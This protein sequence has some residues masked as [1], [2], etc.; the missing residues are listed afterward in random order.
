M[1]ESE[2]MQQYPF[3]LRAKFLPYLINEGLDEKPV[4]KGE[5]YDSKFLGQSMHTYL[6]HQSLDG[7]RQMQCNALTMHKWRVG[8]EP[9]SGSSRRRQCSACQG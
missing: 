7:D 1:L 2:K 6:C 3:T 5:L 4:T 8:A 9:G